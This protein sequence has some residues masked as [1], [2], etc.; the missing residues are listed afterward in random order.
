M[1]F[2]TILALILTACNGPIQVPSGG[3]LPPPVQDVSTG[4]DT[5][6]VGDAGTASDQSDTPESDTSGA[7]TGTDYDLDSVRETTLAKTL[8]ELFVDAGGLDLCRAAVYALSP[9]LDPAVCEGLAEDRRDRCREQREPLQTF[10]TSVCTAVLDESKRLDLDPLLVL[11]VIE[12]ESSMG[13]VEFDT[14]KASY[15]VET[16]ICSWFLSK[17][18][19]RTREPGRREGT[20]RISWV[21]GDDQRVNTQQVRVLEE[22]DEGLRIDTC[23]AGEAGIMQTIPREWRS[24]TV[25]EATGDRLTGSTAQRRAQVISDPA[26]QVRLGCQALAEHR[27]L[28][29]ET[30]RGAWTSWIFSYNLGKCDPTSSKAHEYLGK[31]RRHYLDACEGYVP[32]ESGLPKLI[33]D[34]WPECERVENR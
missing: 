18:R 2:L 25:I 27:D 7:D 14:S 9:E 23:V 19:I 16:D 32:D 13:R 22:T 29:P 33:R 4:V 15:E 11:A 8:A 17:T 31:I 1:R 30:L 28:C 6:E 34:L 24:G 10:V 3:G 12:R 21:Y 20:E 26:L 5:P